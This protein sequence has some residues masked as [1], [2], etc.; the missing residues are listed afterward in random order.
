MLP[1]WRRSMENALGIFGLLVVG[2]LI[3]ASYRR[4]RMWE[5]E[6]SDLPDE[7]RAPL[8]PNERNYGRLQTGITAF[9]WVLAA[10]LALIL[11]A[12]YALPWLYP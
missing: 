11:A 10:I 12:W 6:Q 7:E 9:W 1:H 5:A 2:L 3:R 8:F 4:W